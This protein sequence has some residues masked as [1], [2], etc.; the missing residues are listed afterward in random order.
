MILCCQRLS[1][2]LCTTKRN[3]LFL[4]YLYTLLIYVIYF[5]CLFLFLLCFVHYYLHAMLYLCIIHKYYYDA[6]FFSRCFVYHTTISIHYLSVND[7]GNDFFC[8]QKEDKL[9]YVTLGGIISVL[10]DTYCKVI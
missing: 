5:Y 4:F 6:L 10:A 9:A 1:V 2:H 7:N 8:M 3:L